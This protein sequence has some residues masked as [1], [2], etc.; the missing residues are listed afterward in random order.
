MTDLCTHMKLIFSTKFMHEKAVDL[1]K[2]V[3][4]Y[5]FK[6]NYGNTRTIREICS[7]LSMKT[8]DQLQGCCSGV[9]IFNFE[10]ISVTSFWC[11]YC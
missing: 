3:S 10:H 7:T 11:R 4:I 1:F 2:P 8:T 9:L 6:F 5:L